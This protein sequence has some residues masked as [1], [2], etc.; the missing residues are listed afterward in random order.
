MPSENEYY[1]EIY[2]GHR[3]FQ[4][5]PRGE[6]D[7]LGPALPRALGARKACLCSGASRRVKKGIIP[8]IVTKIARGGFCSGLR[9]RSLFSQLWVYLD[10]GFP[11]S[12]NKFK[13]GLQCLSILDME[14]FAGITKV[15]IC[16]IDLPW[17]PLSLYLFT[18]SQFFVGLLL[19]SHMMFW[20]PHT[21]MWGLR[22]F[23]HSRS[24]HLFWQNFYSSKLFFVSNSLPYFAWD[25]YLQSWCNV[26][27][28]NLA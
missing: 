22:S 16:F 6:K 18:S 1:P 15:C 21:W 11:Y 4:P 25:L 14:S 19:F 24:L 10:W 8:E 9:E 12:I 5:H 28:R 27:F 17:R 13:S 23:Y 7:P 2:I 26:A 3:I 20:N